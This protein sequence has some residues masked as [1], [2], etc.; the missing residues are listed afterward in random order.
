MEKIKKSKITKH[1]LAV[2]FIK[3]R[4]RNFYL[5]LHGLIIYGELYQTYYSAGINRHYILFRRSGGFMVSAYDFS[6]LSSVLC[7]W[8]SLQPGASINNEKRNAEAERGN[9]A[10]DQHR[11]Q[12]KG[13]LL[14]VAS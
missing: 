12:G 4:K 13:E 9:P 6:R 5:F 1:P 10:M 11:I 14:A 8:V 7:S 2:L 3:I